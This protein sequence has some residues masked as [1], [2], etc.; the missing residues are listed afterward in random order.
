[1][2]IAKFRN[3]YEEVSPLCAVVYSSLVDLATKKGGK[4]M[5][6]GLKL[7]ACLDDEF[8]EMKDEKCT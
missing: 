4:K 2:K 8:K 7:I 5:W 1:M 3:G 6:P